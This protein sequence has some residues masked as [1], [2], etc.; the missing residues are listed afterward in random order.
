MK[1]MV[2]DKCP[3]WKYT[4]N[5]YR[6]RRS[7]NRI[8]RCFG[9]VMW[10]LPNLYMCLCASNKYIFLFLL[11]DSHFN[12]KIEAT[13]WS[14]KSFLRFVHIVFHVPW[15]QSSSHHRFDF[16]SM[17]RKM[18]KPIFPLSIPWNI[19]TNGIPSNFLI[20]LMNI[21]TG[22]TDFLLCVKHFYYNK[23]FY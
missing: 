19:S 3:V 20:S 12:S 1:K 11:T 8:A 6:A 17:F 23:N 15:F 4:F 22:E 13:L 10:S 7:V 16:I 5:V 21:Q 2:M 18:L 9:G 14:K